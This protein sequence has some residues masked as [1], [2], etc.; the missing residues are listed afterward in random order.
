MPDTEY[1][2]SDTI[3]ITRETYRELL[4]ARYLQTWVRENLE[5]GFVDPYWMPAKLRAAYRTS[6]QVAD[7][8]VT[9]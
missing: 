6:L 3:T 9:V 8:A 5:L 1:P 7:G 4:G 2:Q